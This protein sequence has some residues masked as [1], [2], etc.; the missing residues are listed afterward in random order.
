MNRHISAVEPR[1]HVKHHVVF[2]CSSQVH[3]GAFRVQED[4][5]PA[6]QRVLVPDVPGAAVL[7]LLQFLYTAG[8]SIPGSLQ[9][10]VLELASRSVEEKLKC[11]LCRTSLTMKLLH[12]EPLVWRRIEDKGL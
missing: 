9:P 1:H 12:L 7:A 5:A 8:V 10:H 3:E 4:D 2:I 6:S 11:V